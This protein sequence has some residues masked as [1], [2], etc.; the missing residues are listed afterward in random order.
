[1]RQCGGNVEIDFCAAHLSCSFTSFFP[2]VLSLFN[3][4][5]CRYTH[6]G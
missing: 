2:F 5:V 1:M 3:E 4:S 6:R